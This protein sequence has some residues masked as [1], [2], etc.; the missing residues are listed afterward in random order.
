[1]NRRAIW[2]IICLVVLNLVFVSA[3]VAGLSFLSPR[4]YREFAAVA[5][6]G[7]YTAVYQ[8]PNRQPQGHGGGEYPFPDDHISDTQ[9]Q[10]IEDQLQAS[11]QQLQ[12]EGALPLTYAPEAV[13]FGWPV[14]PAAYLDDYGYHGIS[15]FVDHNPNFPFQ[16]RDYACGQRTYD[17][18][19]GYNHPGTD[20]F[21]WPFPWRR[22]N[23]NEIL[24][25]AAAPGIIVLK[26]D[27][28]Y[29]LNCSFN[30]MPWNAIYIQHSD[31]SIAWY[32]HL[33]NGSLTPKQ[34]GQWVEAGEYL[35]VMGS[36]GNSTGPH[37]HFEVHA[38]NGPTLDP[39]AG[40]CNAMNPE[41]MWL[42]QPPYY[43]TAVN[44]ITTGYAAPLI[45][46]CITPEQSYETDSF[47]PGDTV[48]FTTYYRDQLSNLPSQYTIHRPDGSVYQS[49]QHSIPDPYYAASWWW[50]AY[51]LPSNAPHG[52]WQF[53]VAINNQTYNHTFLVGNPPPPTPTPTAT[54]PPA[55]TPT[56]AAI[57]V[58]LPNGGELFAPGDVLSVT[59][60][61]VLTPAMQVDLLH[62]EEVSQTLTLAG[63]DLITWTIPISA[64]T[65]LYSI[66][67]SNTLSPTQ[68]DESDG[69]FIIGILDHHHFLPVI[70]K[71]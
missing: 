33:K 41:S 40:V 47:N 15:N 11:V 21:S 37:V 16:R 43:D 65:A 46:Q 4:P 31:G 70:L 60:Q 17:T 32:A 71:P 50:W 25:V 29:D 5:V 61:T 30:G 3:A 62:N 67:V 19:S 34:I 68:Y 69:P 51:A 63:Y 39:Y 49:W 56:P 27:G 59:W 48:Y 52:Y 57:T 22:M 55:P 44:K 28:N 20:I 38:W 8:F 13:T 12:N 7:G 35:G 9:R 23:D 58:T 66:R 54:P 36:S 42:V 45:T 6:N 53:T 2:L 10:Q 26:E 64:S 14:Q 24:I 18:A 1:M